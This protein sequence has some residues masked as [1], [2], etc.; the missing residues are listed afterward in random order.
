MGF[1]EMWREL[2]PIG[3]DPRDGGYHRSPFHSAER[4]CVSWYI[5]QA[6]DRGL[7][8][9]VDGQGNAVAWWWPDEPLGLGL[10][11]CSHLDS[12]VSGGAFDGPLGVVSSFAA[13]DAL[14]ESGFTPRRP[15]GV[16][17]FVE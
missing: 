2:L 6:T 11:I 4:E 12:V 10:L 8:V 15:I 13:I 3:R 17:M 14:S 5:D 16:G 1:E 9:R 7:D